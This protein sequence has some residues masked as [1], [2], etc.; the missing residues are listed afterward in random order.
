MGSDDHDLKPYHEL[1]AIIPT[2]ELYDRTK[3]TIIEVTSFFANAKVGLV[4]RLHAALLLDQYHVSYTPLVYQEKLKHVLGKDNHST[5]TLQEIEQEYD[6][7]KVD[8]TH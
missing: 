8:Y 6:Q 4:T 3:H 5:S 1:K 7:A 2:L